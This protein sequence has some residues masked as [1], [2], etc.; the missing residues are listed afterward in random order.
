MV[1]RLID[2]MNGLVNL[3]LCA[4]FSIVLCFAGYA[5]WDMWH[6]MNQAGLSEELLSYQPSL[7]AQEEANPSL[8]ELMAM[9]P[10]VVGWV[11]LDNTSINYPI[12]RGENNT[13]YLNHN[14][15][16]EYSLAGSAFL[17]YRNAAD[18]TDAYSVLYGHNMDGGR[19]FADLKKY[20][21]QDFFNKN[22]TGT[23]FMAEHT[24]ALE[25]YA[26]LHVDVYETPMFTLTETPEEY[27]QRLAYIKESALFYR[28]IGVQGDQR[29]MA[30]STCSS[31]TNDDRTI[32]VARLTQQAGGELP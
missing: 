25:I 2:G 21:S 26:C 27:V 15:Y 6:V 32:V 28:E 17:D 7:S 30:L 31:A 23:L 20:E 1:R 5:L 9:N 18:F 11:Q 22:T 13:Y 29:I 12:L 4:V 16:K 10:D 24:Y 14:F 8:L 3:I 19:M